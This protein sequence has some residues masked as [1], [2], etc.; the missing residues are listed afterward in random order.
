MAACIYSAARPLAARP[1]QALEARS[2]ARAVRKPLIDLRIPKAGRRSHPVRSS[3]G[4]TSAS[5][6]ETSEPAAEK[7][8]SS[9]DLEHVV[10]VCGHRSIDCPSTD[11]Y[12]NL[13]V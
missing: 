4:D 11:A 9:E 12:L 3:S 1:R 7:G 13:Y 8:M 10:P 2:A 6:T 5:S